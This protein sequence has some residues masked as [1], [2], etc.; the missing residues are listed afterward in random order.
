MT[1]YT[2]YRVSMVVRDTAAAGEVAA[3]LIEWF[4]PFELEPLPMDQWRLLMKEDLLE[5]ADAR[6]F[7]RSRLIEGRPI[8]VRRDVTETAGVW[9][10]GL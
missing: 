2:R 4:T 7:L 9:V 5:H 1:E 3:F 8:T 10:A 6:E